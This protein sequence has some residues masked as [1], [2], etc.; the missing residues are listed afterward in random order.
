MARQVECVRRHARAQRRLHLGRRLEVPV[1]RH[2]VVNTLMRAMEVVVVDVQTD[3]ASCVRQ[4]VEDRRLHAIPP[5]RSPEPLDLPERLRVARPRDDMLD[6][7]TLAQL[8]ERA[9]PP[10][11]LVLRPVVRQDLLGRAVVRDRRLE[12]LTDHRA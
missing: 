9:L 12:H 8:R 2:Q 11:R 10:P 5:Q 7:T 1:R 4:I 3:P 6:P